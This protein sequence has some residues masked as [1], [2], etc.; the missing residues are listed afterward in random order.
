MRSTTTILSVIRGAGLDE[1]CRTQPLLNESTSQPTT[2]FA[3]HVFESLEKD[4][5]EQLR[6]LTWSAVELLPR[7]RLR[8]DRKKLLRACTEHEWSIRELRRAVLSANGEQTC[9]A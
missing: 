9:Q 6:D 2:G 1:R 7:V 8:K 3:R 4:E 5:L